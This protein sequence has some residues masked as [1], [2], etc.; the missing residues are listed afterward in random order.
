LS[1]DRNAEHTFALLEEAGQRVTL[2]ELTRAARHCNLD[3]FKRGLEHVGGWENLGDNDKQ[4][5]L[6]YAAHNWDSEV[7]IY[8][9]EEGCGSNGNAFDVVQSETALKAACGVG[10]PATVVRLLECDAW[11]NLDVDGGHEGMDSENFAIA[12]DEGSEGGGAEKMKALLDRGC[13]PNGGSIKAARASALRHDNPDVAQLLV[14]KYPMDTM[15]FIEALETETHPCPAPVRTF[16]ENCQPMA[17]NEL[18]EVMQG[19]V[20]RMCGWLPLQE[21]YKRD[22][23]DVI[24]ILVQRPRKVNYNQRYNVSHEWSAHDIVDIVKPILNVRFQERMA[25]KIAEQTKY[26]LRKQNFNDDIKGLLRAL[27]GGP[28]YVVEEQDEV[29]DPNQHEG[30]DREIERAD[31]DEGQEEGEGEGEE[32]GEEEGEDEGEDDN[33]EEDE[34]EEEDD[35][36]GDVNM[37]NNGED[38]DDDNDGNMDFRENQNPINNEDD[39]EDDDED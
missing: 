18:L 37:N 29:F 25:L 35:N 12:A 7:P 31:D 2:R 15:E 14:E 28:H 26:N 3:L 4:S 21:L 39:D 20:K 32:E 6:V 17:Y 13:N 27:H 23:E 19:I 8:V 5:M 10:H 38:E 9:L 34:D 1:L 22:L 16:S 24:S 36:E 11:P 33:N 30:I